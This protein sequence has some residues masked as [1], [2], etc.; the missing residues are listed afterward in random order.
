MLCY[1][2]CIITLGS[3]IALENPS[4]QVFYIN[5]SL[6]SETHPLVFREI[7]PIKFCEPKNLTSHKLRSAFVN[8]FVWFGVCG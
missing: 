4:W 5:N 1:F 8:V 2:N 7:L 6:R 3:K